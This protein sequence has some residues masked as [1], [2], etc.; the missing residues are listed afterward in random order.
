MCLF[1]GFV[2]SAD[3]AML[4]LSPFIIFSTSVIVTTLPFSL[5]FFLSFIPLAALHSHLDVANSGE[6]CAVLNC[7]V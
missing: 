6:L 5:S 7:A 1:L 2:F 4:P 3:L